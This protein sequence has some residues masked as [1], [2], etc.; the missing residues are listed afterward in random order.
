MIFSIDIGTWLKSKQ[1]THQRYGN[2]SMET[3]MKT[4]C[5]ENDHGVETFVPYKKQGM[6]NKFTIL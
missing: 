6:K 2:L 1:S 4:F 3:C 5:Q